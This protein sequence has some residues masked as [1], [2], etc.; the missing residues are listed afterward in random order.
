MGTNKKKKIDKG[1][2]RL[3]RLNYARQNKRSN[4]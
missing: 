2:R 1:K 3:T 4:S